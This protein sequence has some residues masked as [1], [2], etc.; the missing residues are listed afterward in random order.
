MKSIIINSERQ[1]KYAESLIDEMP[2]NG[3]YV[4]EIKQV[5]DS[6]TAKQRRLAWRWNDEVSKSGLGSED[7]KESVHT[8][9]KWMFARPILL[10]DDEL[11][12]LIY[13][14]FIE[15]VTGSATYGE[16]CRAFSEQYISTEKMTRKQ[17]SEYLT[18]F[19]RFWTGKGLELTDPSTLGLD[20]YLGGK[21]GK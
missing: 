11:F 6:P 17:R 2:A 4:V 12:G 18:D 1:K 9:A 16:F 14:K 20:E 5:D 10:R 8:K 19:Q 15:T 13:E 3:T 21:N 7:T